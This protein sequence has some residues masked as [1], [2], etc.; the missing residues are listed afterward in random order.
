LLSS[1]Q[2]LSQ[3]NFKRLPFLAREAMTSRPLQRV[4][5]LAQLLPIL[6]SVGI[7]PA[8]I[9]NGLDIGAADLMPD[10]VI[11]FETGLSI[12]ERAA[13]ATGLPHLGALVGAR[14]DHR[15]LGPVGDLMSS[16]PT[17]GEALSDYVRVQGGI[18]QAASAYL[19]PFGEGFAFGFGIYDR[20]APGADQAYGVAIAA[21]A[22]I[23]RSLTGG[24]VEPQ[25]VL[26][27][28]RRP[29]DVQA[30][31]RA[32]GCE[33]HFDQ[34]QSCVL[35]SASSLEAILSTADAKRR[36]ESSA[37]LDA[38]LALQRLPV[39]TRLRHK[40]RPLLS[41]GE[42]SLAAAAR[43][44]GFS[45][46]TLNRH[47]LAEQTTFTRERDAVR[48]TMARELLTLTDLH[49]GEIAVALS[50]ATPSAFVRAFRRWTGAA[51][52][53]WRAVHASAEPSKTSG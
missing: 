17:L 10:R 21:G 15:C 11:A 53:H 24:E 19:I 23:V 2:S 13:R 38:L 39:A 28:H 9:L 3:L 16:A 20:Q 7:A 18:S 25:A 46:R 42:V 41:T 12:L 49:A 29:P 6:D 36:A 30:F 5:P 14:N 31:R 52:T 40:L 47:L 34:H 44:L 50:Y 37:R 26:L 27:G 1:L 45:A 22:N 48:L 32:M 35:L 51:P 4:G 43:S 8:S 33:V